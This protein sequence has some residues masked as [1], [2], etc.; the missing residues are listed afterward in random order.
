MCFYIQYIALM[1]I[2]SICYLF[3][4][5]RYIKM[6]AVMDAV[7]PACACQVVS[8]LSFCSLSL[9]MSAQYLPPRKHL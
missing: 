6:M 7:G 1:S 8:L 9:W 3:N 5:D 4:A 2:V